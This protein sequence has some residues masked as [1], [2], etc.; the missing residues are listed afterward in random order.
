MFC[1]T[2][3]TN[4]IVDNMFNSPIFKHCLSMSATLNRVHFSEKCLSV[5]LRRLGF[6]RGYCATA[7][8]DGSGEAR[9]IPVSSVKHSGVMYVD[10]LK[11]ARYLSQRAFTK[12]QAEAISEML[13]EILDAVTDH[14]NKTMV[15]KPQQEIMVQQLMAQIASVKK[16]M[17]ILEKSEFNMIRNDTEKQGAMIKQLEQ[18]MVDDL[19]K[20]AGQVKLDL[21]LEKSRAIEAHAINEKHLQATNN[22]LEVEEAKNEKHLKALEDKIEIELSNLRTQNEKYRNDFL[23]FFI[24]SVGSVAG[25]Y[26]AYLRIMM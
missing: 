11:L 1:K 2:R 25:L 17:V 26:L 22:K 14:Q 15:T 5:S 18:K 6:Y 10:T 12:E 24:G 23:K 19:K 13:A 9:N 4:A 3:E 21:N 16:D 20:L 8:G 7:S